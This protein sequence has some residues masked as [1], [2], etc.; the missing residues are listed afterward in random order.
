VLAPEHG[1][2]QELHRNNQREARWTEV[3]R[4]KDVGQHLPEAK[5][6]EK[7]PEALMLLILLGPLL[8]WH[9]TLGNQGELPWLCSHTSSHGSRW[10]CSPSVPLSLTLCV[11]S[12]ILAATGGGHGPEGAGEGAGHE[13]R[14]CGAR[15]RLQREQ[16]EKRHVHETRVTEAAPT[17]SPLQQ[18]TRNNSA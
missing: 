5:D 8:L 10:P 14:T 17:L 9:L 13:Q 7:G 4:G 3:R 12:A 11:A 6:A 18:E 16:G 2:H 1:V 15:L